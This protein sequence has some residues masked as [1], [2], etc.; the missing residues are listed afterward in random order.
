M[1]AAMLDRSRRNKAYLARA[2]ANGN[3]PLTFDPRVAARL[4]DKQMATRRLTLKGLEDASGVSWRNLTNIRAGK[5]A[6]VR[7]S[8]LVALR[9]LPHLSTPKFVPAGGTRARL[10]MLSA[11]GYSVPDLT[12]HFGRA[13][14]LYRRREVTHDL[15]I[16]VIAA[17]FELGQRLGPHP[18]A[19]KH[20]AAKGY[21]PPSAYDQD[22]LADS[23][24]DGTGGL[25]EAACPRD[26]AAEIRFL[27]SQGVDHVEIAHQLDVERGRVR[28]TLRRAIR[29]SEQLV[30]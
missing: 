6:Y 4:I 17:L 24:W 13:V 3:R 15:A 14:A 8:T 2:A 12:T 23:T 25:L 1:T 19:A 27:A 28:D 26:V 22:T 7:R 16:E 9:D 20:A 5:V 18:F 10:Q 29:P 30:A 21:L 11:L